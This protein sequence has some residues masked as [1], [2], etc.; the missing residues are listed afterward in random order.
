MRSLSRKVLV[1]LLIVSALTAATAASA[2]AAPEWY[3]KTHGVYKKVTGLA[4]KSTT[5]KLIVTDTRWG[6]GVRT[7]CEVTVEGTLASGG[8]GTISGYNVSKCEASPPCGKVTQVEDVHLPWK[9][10][11]YK[12]G[13]GEFR[14]KIVSGGSGTPA[15]E[16]QCEVGGIQTKDVCNLDTSAI[17]RNGLEGSVESE[18]SEGSKRTTCEI[19]GAEAGKWEGAIIFPQPKGVEAIEVVEGGPLE[20]QQ[21]GKGLSEAAATAWKGTMKL[22]DSETTNTV[23]CEDTVEGTAGPGVAGTVT[24]WTASKCTT[25]K[26][27]CVSPVME[28]VHL[29]WH[30]EL[31]ISAEKTQDT[32]TE[33][34]KGSPGYQMKCTVL[35]IKVTDECTATKLSTSMENATAS[36]EAL[37]DGEKLNCT[38]GGWGKGSVEGTQLVEAIKGG[39]L[40]VT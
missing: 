3:A 15:W 33:G 19:G 32:I 25:T 2:F 22:T 21:G 34:G 11:L 18:F 27:T 17:V 37:F 26:G 28:A 5:K 1:V 7:A 9:T 35:G 12:V 39:R 31:N 8:L 20:W 16:F 30:S 13:A 4:V 6:K 23:E 36:V 14:E 24:K 38:V 29:P 10:E 40:T